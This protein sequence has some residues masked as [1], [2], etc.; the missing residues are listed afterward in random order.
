MEGG[1]HIRLLSHAV[2]HRPRR[3]EYDSPYP[4]VLRG[5]EERGREDRHIRLNE[6][7]RDTVQRGRQRLGRRQIPG[8]NLGPSRQGGRLRV[9]GQ[10]PDLIAGSQELLDYASTNGG[11]CS[12]NQDHIATPFLANGFSSRDQTGWPGSRELSSRRLDQ[13]NRRQNV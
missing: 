3:L 4:S 9:T 1:N 11:G 2:H 10:G 6:H 5:L 13:R 12:S 7:S 8:D